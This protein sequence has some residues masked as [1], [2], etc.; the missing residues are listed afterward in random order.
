MCFTEVYKPNG[1]HDKP[2]F[3]LQRR[4]TVN[5]KHVQAGEF[6]FFFTSVHKTETNTHSPFSLFNY[7]YRNKAKLTS[8]SQQK[9]NVTNI[10]E[11]L[12]FKHLETTMRNTCMVLDQIR[13]T[14]NSKNDCYY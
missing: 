5:Y 6:Y 11:I 10:Q 3:V 2:A 4:P 12:D 14:I 1:Q 9:Q 7:I 13:S 8:K